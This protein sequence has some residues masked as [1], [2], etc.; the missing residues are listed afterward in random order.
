MAEDEVI[1]DEMV[2]LGDEADFSDDMDLGDDDLI[3]DEG[4]ETEA[5]SREIE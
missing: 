5:N 4:A 1:E 2:D 3:V